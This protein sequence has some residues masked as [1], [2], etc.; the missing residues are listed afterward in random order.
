MTEV[1]GNSKKFSVT[2]PGLIND[3]EIGNHIL[4]DDGQINLVVK[5][6]TKI[7]RNYL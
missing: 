7:K 3:V 6:L 5:R 1:L 4:I 2:Y